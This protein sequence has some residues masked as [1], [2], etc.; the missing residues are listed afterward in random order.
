MNLYFLLEGKR[1][2][3]KIYPKW[4]S[5]LLPS[6]NKIQS[7]YDAY[8]N[9]YYMFSGMGYP[10]LLHNHLK[11]SI[12]EVNEIGVYNYLI[13]VLDSEDETIEQRKSE[14]RDFLQ[15]NKIQSSCEIKI[16]VQHRC[17]ETWL[18][19]NKKIFKRN[20]EDEELL[21]FKNFYDVSQKD[22]EKCPKFQGYNTHALFHLDY[23]KAV[24]NERKLNYSK[25][26]PR[27]VTEKHYLKELINRTDEGHIA[28]F[29]DLLTFCRQIERQTP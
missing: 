5:V 14:V 8:N 11:N 4:L 9:N 22:P 17:I 29:N 12:E 24:L 26:N 7:A 25:N 20:P 28:S 10:S 23:L 27:D 2:E 6:Y 21:A 15:K 16:I 13:I 18:L 1:T 19:G 3:P